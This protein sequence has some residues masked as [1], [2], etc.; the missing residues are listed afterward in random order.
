MTIIDDYFKTHNK[1]IDIYGSKT[2]FLD[3]IGSFYEAYQTNTEGPNLNTISNILN[4]LVSKKNKSIL[5]VDRKNP[6]M[7]GFPCVVLSKYLKLL[8]ENNYTV[9]ISDQ[10]TPPPNPKRKIVGIYSPGTYLEDNGQQDNNYMLS[11]F[12]ENNTYISVGLCLLDL[13]TGIS[14]IHEIHNNK[15]DDK[16]ALDEAIKFINS[17]NISEILIITNNI[18]LSKEELIDYLELSNK[19]YQYKTLETLKK[20]NKSIINI[21]YQQEFLSKIYEDINTLTPIEYLGLEK[22]EF[23]RNAFIILLIYANDHNSKILTRLHKP[24]IY[25]DNKYLHLGNDALHQ[26]Q[27]ISSDNKSLFDIIN[28]TNTPM[29]KRMLKNTLASPIID[30]TELNNR[31]DMIEK[32][33]ND[34]IDDI[35]IKICDIEKL[36]RKIQLNIIHPLELY[37]WYQSHKA[38]EEL[39]FGSDI[40]KDAYNSINNHK[41][42]IMYIEKTFKTEE[43][44]KYLLNDITDN[45]FNS[46]IHADVD[47]LEQD[48][49]TCNN[50]ISELALYLGELIN[51]SIKIESNDREGYYLSLTKIRCDNLQKELKKINIIKIG[52]LKLPVDKLVYKHAVKGNTKIFLPELEKNSDKI[53]LITN[54]IRVLVKKY[55]L[56][57]LVELNKFKQTMENCVNIIAKLDFLR[58]GA[59]IAI[60]NKYFKPTLIKDNNSFIKIK[61][62]RHPIVEAINV[63]TE[64]VPHDIHL[65]NE[66][67]GVLLFG[68][69]SAGKSTLQK[70]IGISV[71]LAQ[72]GY[73]VPAEE[74]ILAP[75]HSIFTRI[76]G[77]DNIFKGLSSF[78]QELVDL[79]AIIKRSGKNTLVIA[80]EVCKGTEHTSSLIIVMTMIEMLSNSNTNFIT[81]THLHELCNF[82][83]LKLLQNIKQYHLHVEFDDINNTLIYD[84]QLKEGPGISFY[85]LQVAK[86][87]MNDTIFINTASEIHKEYGYKDI[88]NDK[89]SN[90]NSAIHM[91]ECVICKITPKKNEIPLESHHIDF[92]KNTD[93]D[94]F[95]LTKKHKHKNHYTNLVVL[96]HKCHNDIDTGELIIDG[97]KKT[98]H[99]KKLI[100]KKK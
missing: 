38:I 82:D 77:N 21:A 94:G 12:I 24:D 26:L 87:L 91:T 48:L 73:Y 95:I 52:N 16:I 67:S 72:I 53:I 46:E 49:K 58:S 42:M 78:T 80:D 17:Y 23:G 18:T 51:V 92:Q 14:V 43:L 65:D 66:Q 75:Y 11:I 50:F 59:K 4:I 10:V 22:M 99:G 20:T 57:Y 36:Q 31:Y 39:E 9:I 35:L 93:E 62:L 3:Q 19:T 40:C 56:E 90:Y 34:N 97:Y 7:L 15:S 68:L 44:S 30:I 2:L 70:A 88:V 27:I 47:S 6:Y 13:T 89:K 5:S 85:G 64:Y 28:K 54:K 100:Y 45:I 55:Y 63:T 81:A 8:I 86:Y 83:R 69:N 79:R 37:R 96:C 32:L 76:S 41:E 71:I 60:K 74:F 61:Q 98:A 33:K 1:Y 29:G 84:R 25:D